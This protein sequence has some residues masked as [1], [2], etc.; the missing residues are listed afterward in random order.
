MKSKQNVTKTPNKFVTSVS[1]IVG[2]ENN[3][4]VKSSNNYIGAVKVCGIDIENYKD[5]DREIAF[6]AFGNALSTVEIPTKYVFCGT[7]PDYSQQI[8]NFAVHEL[9]QK[10][11]FRKSILERERGWLEAYEQNYEMRMVYVLFFS[12]DTKT[13]QDNMDKYISC[14]KRGKLE[15]SVCNEDD[16]VTIFDTL[17]CGG[18]NK[19]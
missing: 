18:D 10:N 9:K 8:R 3:T 16:F 12:H 4:F 17:L 7:K 5:Q 14:L 13:I 2:I 15:A 6:N 11:E 19:C 1:T